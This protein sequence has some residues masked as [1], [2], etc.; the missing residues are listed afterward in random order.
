MWSALQ[1]LDSRMT[2]SFEGSREGS[3]NQASRKIATRV[4]RQRCYRNTYL[5]EGKILLDLG[6]IVNLVMRN[7]SYEEI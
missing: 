4:G 2:G 3:C 7:Y 5:K 6:G 1:N